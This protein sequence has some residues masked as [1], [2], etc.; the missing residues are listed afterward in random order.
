M[1]ETGGNHYRH[2]LD[3]RNVAAGTVLVASSQALAT[4]SLHDGTVGLLNELPNPSEED[5]LSRMQ[6]HLCRCCHYPK[7]LK[8]IRRAAG[9]IP[10]VARRR[11][12]F[13]MPHGNPYNQR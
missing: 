3:S 1:P 5:I 8:A 6:R 2:Y 13:Q 12:G 11:A 7:L 9:R 10:G 4:V